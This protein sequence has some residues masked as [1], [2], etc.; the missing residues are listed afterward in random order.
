MLRLGSSNTAVRSRKRLITNDAR[1]DMRVRLGSS[2]AS[3]DSKGFNLEKTSSH[4]DEN[5]PFLGA[6]T[7]ACPTSFARFDDFYRRNE[8]KFARQFDL[9]R[10]TLNENCFLGDA[11]SPVKLSE[12]FLFP[13]RSLKYDGSY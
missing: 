12:F 2:H 10:S 7:Q 4:P 1:S 11:S 9:Y 6:G 3:S 13:L 5:N 8:C